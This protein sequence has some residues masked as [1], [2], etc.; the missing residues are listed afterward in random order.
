MLLGAAFLMLLF[1]SDLYTAARFGMWMGLSAKKPNQAFAKTVLYV[2]V[3]PL[4]SLLC[5]QVFGPLIMF[6]KNA[7]LTNYAQEKLRQQLRSV[8]VEGV[9]TKVEAGRLPSVIE[10]TLGRS[11]AA[12]E[13]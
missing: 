2:L 6:L 7:M 5:C 10:D 13:R 1:V 3:L 11:A 9:V 8:L 4:F 12:W